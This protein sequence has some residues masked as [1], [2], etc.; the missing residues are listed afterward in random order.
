MVEVFENKKE[1]MG[2]LSL[3]LDDDYVMK[4][5]DMQLIEM[6]IITPDNYRVLMKDANVD[7]YVEFF[8]KVYE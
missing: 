5:M 6:F 4:D 3:L 2:Y 1:G 7:E 8:R